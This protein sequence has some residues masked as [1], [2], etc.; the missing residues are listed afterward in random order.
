MPDIYSLCKPEKP[1]HVIFDSPHSG[2]IYPADF[3][4]NADDM[5]L[6]ACEDHFV[7]EL[8]ETAPALGGM[9][10]CANFPRTYI[11]LN[12]SIDDIDHE[13]LNAPWQ[14]EIY[15][16]NRSLAG[17]GLIRR[18][19]KQ[20]TPLYNRPLSQ[21]EIQNRIDQYYAPYYAQLE[22]L[23][24]KTHTKFGKVLHINCHSM[25]A[26]A[27]TIKTAT[28]FT[29]GKTQADFVI[30]DRNGMT[31]S[32]Q[33]TRAIQKFIFDL[34][35]S[36][37][38]NDP[39]QGVELIH[40]FS[41]PREQKHALQIEINKALYMNEDTLQKYDGW[42]KLKGDIEKLITFIISIDF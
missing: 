5:D 19:I 22:K 6:R 35:Y 32:P 12:R 8:F 33:I 15:P 17:I 24:Q 18:L 1:S 25:P 14:G 16:T 39:F 2:I 36:V 41:C 3:N 37:T 29:R 11:D 30:G 21:A 23:Y 20:Q 10:L 4:H 28:R 31:C 13:L 42:N 27:A 9:L 38:I 34:G 26:H 40:R 7:D